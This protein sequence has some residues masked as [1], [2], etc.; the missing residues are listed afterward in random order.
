MMCNWESKSWT[1]TVELGTCDWVQCLKPPKPPSSTHLR[2]TDWFGD[3]IEF[4][5][6]IRFVCERGYSFE[7]D[8]AQL[9]VAYTC[10]DGAENQELRGFF[11]VPELEEDWPRCLQGNFKP[12]NIMI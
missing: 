2:V 7:D 6:Q 1:P 10:Q 3:P 8:P 11:D 4:G 5:N 9:D 12:S